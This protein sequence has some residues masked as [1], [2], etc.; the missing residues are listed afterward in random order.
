VAIA[1][2]TFFERQLRQLGQAGVGDVTVVTGYKAEAFDPWRGLSGLEFIHNEH[3]HDRNNLW[4]MHLARERLG[5][6][7]VLDGDVRLADG[8]IPSSA[9][10]T[11]CWF[12]GWRDLMSGE[13]TVRTDDA[14]RVRAIEVRSGSGW[15]L[16]G[17]SYWTAADG[18]IL[19]R[20]VAEAALGPGAESLYWDD[21]P[22]RSLDLIDVR[23][24]R[25]GSR[26][27]AEVDSLEDKAAL[28]AELAAPQAPQAPQATRA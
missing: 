21:I 11:S 1:G 20:L 12:V 9:P 18:E 24:R 6:G 14:D 10:E 15:I 4:T 26:D 22:R 5:G 7:F 17:L 28:E 25:I 13:W 23:A 8:V 2:E 3:Y 19:A 27:W 16:S